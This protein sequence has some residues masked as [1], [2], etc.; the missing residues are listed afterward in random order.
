MGDTNKEDQKLYVENFA[1]TQFALADADERKCETITKKNAI[2][3]NRCGHF[4]S[5]LSLFGELEQDW[6]E[7]AKYCKYKAGTILKAVKAGEQPPRGNPFAPE[8]EPVVAEE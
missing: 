3:F 1:L 2:D 7:K 8:P 6:A 5:L 4:I